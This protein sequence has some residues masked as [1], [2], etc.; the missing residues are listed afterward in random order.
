M[1]ESF[2]AYADMK[3]FGTKCFGKV[4]EHWAYVPL[5]AVMSPKSVTNCP[6]RELLSV[7]LNRGVVLFSDVAEKRTNATSSDLSKYQAVDPGDFVLNNQQAWRGSVG[8]SKYA[9]IVSPAYLVLSLS[10]AL[11]PQYANY[12][13]RDKA[14]VNQYL[15]CSKGV[16]SIQRNLYWP[17]LKR[18]T[19]LIPPIDEQVAIVRYLHAMD[20]KITRFIRN[21]RRLIEVLNEQKQAIINRAVIRGLDPDVTF[22]PSGID[23][24]GDIPARWEIVS[25][26]R[27]CQM[28]SGEGITS[29]D[30]DEN[31]A[32]PV[33]GGNGQRGYTKKY[34]HEGE[35]VLIGR[36][37]ALCGNVHLVSGRFWASE[38]AVVVSLSSNHCIDWFVAL[39]IGMELNQYSIAAAQPGLSVDRIINLRVPLPSVEEQ[40]EI[41]NFISIETD[42][43]FKAIDRAQREINLIREYRTRLITDVVTGKIDVRH[44][45]PPP[46]SEDLEEVAEALEPLD[47]VM[48]DVEIDEEEEVNE[49][50]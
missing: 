32:Y 25:I 44:L 45:V 26:K 50:D 35:Y 13:F 48:A 23:W 17:H 46:G 29:F 22:K 40:K 34:T 5:F 9:G 7:Y 8:V 39:L 21:R 33:Y 41:A 12:L 2:R 31:G 16:G 24:F 38:H 20:L 14:M 37:G 6:D 19:I 49:S 10:S 42:V 28:K 36:Q 15:V 3:D 30:I 4:P 18:V 11:H 47:D 27:I 43:I 1:I